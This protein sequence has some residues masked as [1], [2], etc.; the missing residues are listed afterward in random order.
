MVEYSHLSDRRWNLL[1]LTQTV[2]PCN[3]NRQHILYL[4]HDN[5]SLALDT[6]AYYN[7]EANA[8]QVQGPDLA[9]VSAVQWV[10]WWSESYDTLP[11]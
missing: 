6:K 4:Q 5:D 2:S 8:R 11:V 7:L 1:Y 10:L 9:N 3:W